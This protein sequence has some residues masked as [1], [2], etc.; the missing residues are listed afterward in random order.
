MFAWK[1]AK[2]ILPTRHA[3]FVRKLEVG[4]CCLLCDREPETSFHATVMCPQAYGLRQAMREFWLLPDEQQ[5]IYNGPDWFLLLLDNCSSVQRDLVKLLLWRAWTT[6][7]NI[8]HQSGQMGIYDGVQF[9][10]SMR[11][12]LDQIKEV[13]VV[14]WLKARTHLTLE[15]Q[16]RS[17]LRGLQGLRVQPSVGHLLQVGAKLMWMAPL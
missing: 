14:T 5:F 11:S 2:D 17:R 13:G 7:N 16:G 12:T 8:T 9:L 6:H 15:I 4:D 1:L 3:K 10:L